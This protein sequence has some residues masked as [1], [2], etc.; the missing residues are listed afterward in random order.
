MAKRLGA[1]GQGVVLVLVLL[2]PGQPGSVGTVLAQTQGFVPAAVLSPSCFAFAAEAPQASRQEEPQAVQQPPAPPPTPAP[3]PDELRKPATE[4]EILDLIATLE[5]ASGK[6][7]AGKDVGAAS[8]ARLRVVLDDVTTLLVAT[9]AHETARQ[10]E[11][12]GKPGAEARVWFTE[13]LAA[14]DTCVASKYADRGGPTAHKQ[15]LALVEKHR[16]RLEPLVLGLERWLPLESP[17][18]M[19]GPKPDG[20]QRR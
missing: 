15:S 13:R 18:G 17:P 2:G 1:T 12:G 5:T 20:E 8:A 19:I 3:P 16:E 14:I 6:K 11:K 10:L 9:H 7:P 4:R